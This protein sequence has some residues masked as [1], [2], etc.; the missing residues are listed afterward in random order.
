MI[1]TAKYLAGAL[2]GLCIGISGPGHAA[3]TY[4][5][6]IATWGAPSH[7]HEKF[8]VQPFIDLVQ[9]NSEG[10]IK[11][12][13][14]S[15]G[16]MVQQ[17]TVPNAVATGTV[18]I[19]LT[20]MDTWAGR[21]KDAS[22]TS[23]PVWN[24]SMQQSDKAL[25][26]GQPIL[27]YFEKQFAKDRVTVLALWDAGPTVIVSKVPI[28]EPDDI[29]GKVIRSLSKGGAE[30][31]QALGAA[32]VVLNV[33]EV[34][35]ALQRGT[36]DGAMNGM[37]GAV[38]LKYSEVT[39]YVLTPNGVMGTLISGYV[40]NT[41]KLESLPPELQKVVL[42]A[43]IT[44]RKSVQSEFIS[45]YPDFLKT[46]EAGGMESFQLTRGTK[47]WDSWSAALADLREKGVKAY[48]PGLVQQIQAAAA[49]KAS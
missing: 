29:K 2:A 16:T 35:G 30:V 5:L 22:V 18:D 28:H 8:F 44:V 38:G 31:L 6:S 48:S 17:H 21:F 26:P 27:K 42:D 32:P 12:K 20:I 10:R 36:I 14:F 15:R 11:F 39:K 23:T 49:D 7:P 37:Q 25:A 34:Y 4:T 1:S 41:R 9:K 46:L 13:Y 19:A 47:E 45:S 24:L 43:A 40:M 3:D 33:G